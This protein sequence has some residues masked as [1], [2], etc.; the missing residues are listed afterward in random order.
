MN[1]HSH[2]SGSTGNLHQITGDAG[3]LLIDPGV[4]IRKIKEALDF[5]L[6][7]VSAAL[8]SHGHRDH[9]KA[10]PEV[11]RMGIDVY[12]P[13]EVF[14]SLQMNGHMTHIIQPMKPFEIGDYRIKAFPTQHDY[15][16]AVGFL[17]ADKS[18][19]MAYITDSFYCK[20]LLPGLSILAI[21]C[22]YSIDTLSP[23]LDPVRKKRLYT[24][25]FSLENVLRFLEANDLRKLRE[26][27][28]IHMSRE[29][30]DPDLFRG[31]IQRATG[32]PTCI[33]G[34]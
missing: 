4:P 1:F 25:H 21:E 13:S 12:A 31:T 32:I 11:A 30:S 28:L 27:H 34:K 23:D 7:G 33:G 26:I 19:K 17:I 10:L 5:K 22:N 6:S 2:Y 20:Y 29:N 16:G 9:C 15:P 8:V 18:E 3:S 14:Q 24:S